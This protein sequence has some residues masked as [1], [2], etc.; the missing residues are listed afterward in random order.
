MERSQEEALGF[1]RSSSPP[2]WGG[3]LDGSRIDIAPLST[4]SVPTV[5]RLG[6]D[7]LSRI[8]GPPRPYSQPLRSAVRAA[9]VRL[10]AW[11]LAMA[12]DR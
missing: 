4:L 8:F 10:R 6:P 11:V 9:S 5:E 12:L 3:P 2:S 1:Q 7:S